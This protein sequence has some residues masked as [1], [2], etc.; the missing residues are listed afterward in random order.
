MGGE[1][2]RPDLV[3]VNYQSHHDGGC[4]NTSSSLDELGILQT[5]GVERQV[6]QGA[7]LPVP[8]SR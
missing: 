7:L 5:T 6:P 4:D 2:V 3:R 8:G 1:V